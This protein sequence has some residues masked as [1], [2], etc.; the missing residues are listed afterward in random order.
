MQG[1]VARFEGED[2]KDD[3]LGRFELDVKTIQKAFEKGA[4][5]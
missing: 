4:G 2:P 5:H 3:P 1:T